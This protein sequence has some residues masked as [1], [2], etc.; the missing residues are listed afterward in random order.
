MAIN[1][2]E[3]YA[4]SLLQAFNQASLTAGKVNTEFEFNGVAAIHIL[5]AVTQALNDYK[6]TG[7]NRYGEP[8]ELQDTKQ[9]LILT[10]DKSFSISIDRGNNDDQM[11]AKKAGTVVKAQIGE[12]VTPFFDQLAITNW[13][14]G[15][16]NHYV[17]TTLDK[18]TVLDC[19]IEAHKAFF[20]NHFQV[21]PMNCF[22]YVKTSTYA[23]LLR[24]PEFISVESLGGKILTNGEV[25]KCMSFTVVETPDTYFPDGIQA[26]FTHKRAVMQPQKLN[27]LFVRTNVQGISGTVIEGR[28][29]GDAFVL[30]ALKNGVF[31]IQTAA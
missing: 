20:N 18:N 19:F 2:A 14:A 22:A 15:A 7:T 28:Y 17:N 30:D 12:Q 6:R 8:T 16:G 5:T 29:R 3:K 23:F 25:G 31:K 21:N 9:D 10:K 27:E 24:N 13:C 11:G 1:L 4:S 26:L